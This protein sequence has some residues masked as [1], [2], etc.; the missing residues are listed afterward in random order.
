MSHIGY[1]YEKEWRLDQLDIKNDFLNG[2]LE[3]DVYMYMPPDYEKIGKCCKLR[4]TSYG[5][6]NLQEHDLMD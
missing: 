1:F 6:N 5:L 4:K 3:E 2:D